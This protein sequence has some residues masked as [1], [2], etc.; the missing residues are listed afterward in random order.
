[1]LRRGL[2]E[3]SR[4]HVLSTS[5]RRP[6]TPGVETATVSVHLNPLA[7]SSDVLFLLWVPQRTLNIGPVSS[8]VPNRSLERSIALYPFR[9]DSSL[10]LMGHRSDAFTWPWSKKE[11]ASVAPPFLLTWPV[12]GSNAILS[13]ECAHELG[14]RGLI[15]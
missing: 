7:M 12:L 5:R 4:G 3:T 13:A 11:L 10:V 1:M 8:V 2:R 6:L 15:W 9:L 14:D